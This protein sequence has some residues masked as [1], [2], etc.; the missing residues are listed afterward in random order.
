M[1]R[2]SLLAPG[3]RVPLF[4]ILLVA[5]IVQHYFGGVFSAPLWIF[6]AFLLFAYRDPD[7]EIPSSPL[8]VVS[9]VDG[10]ITDV[11]EMIDP[12]LDRPS[13][14]IQI[15]MN[16][17]GVFTSRSPI[18]GKVLEP[19]NI[20]GDVSTP[21]GVWLQTDEGDDVVLVMSKGRLNFT[22]RCDIRFGERVG[23]GQRCGF[24]HLGGLIEVYVPAN[25]SVA[26]AKGDR[27]FSGSDIIAELV[28]S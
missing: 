24:I 6:S 27:V 10:K 14:R 13:I 9:P 1:N 2:Y 17:H 12:Y 7:R 19:P 20:P 5:G 21:H 3:G 26:V 28:H 15:R 22:P 18:E 25:S 8:A 23:Q 16:L 11:S 4:L